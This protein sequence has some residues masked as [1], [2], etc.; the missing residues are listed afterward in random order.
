MSNR[1]LALSMRPHSLPEMIGQDEILESL[2]KQFASNRIPHFF[3]ITGPIGCGKT[4][5]SKILA[6]IIQS[7]DDKS[8]IRGIQDLPW[9][10]Y[11]AFDIIEVNAANKNGVDDIRHLVDVMRYKPLAPSKAKIVIMD[12]AHQLTS[13]AQNALLTE[14]EDVANHV[15]YIFC[16]SCITKIIPALQR[17][18]YII[19]PKLLSDQAILELLQ[20]TSKKVGFENDI[21]PLY[22]ALLLH[23]LR[24]PGLILQAIEKYINGTSPHACI[25]TSS[26]III[27]TKELCKSIVSGDWKTSATLLK[28]VTT[29][30]I[31]LLKKYI[32]GY[33]KRKMMKNTGDKAYAIA[34][35]IRILTSC[36]MDE[37]VILSSFLASICLVCEELQNVSTHSAKTSA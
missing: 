30:D 35:A 12:E 29:P 5:L 36:T 21:Q 1:I 31:G 8:D 9:E 37:G 2:N 25:S 16:T 32:L 4:T 14:T 7:I 20:V 11:K 23:D 10:Q 6:L 26:D 28:D 33:L 13:A 17:R 19:N 27:N 22:E 24:S 18:A 3:I 34:R 15:Y